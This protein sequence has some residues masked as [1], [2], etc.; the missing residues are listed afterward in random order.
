MKKEMNLVRFALGLVGLAMSVYIVGY[1][2]KR[3]TEAGAE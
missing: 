2:F 3:G 1:A